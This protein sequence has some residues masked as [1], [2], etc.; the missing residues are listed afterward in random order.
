[1]AR[2]FL[3][4]SLLCQLATSCL[5]SLGSGRAKCVWG[6]KNVSPSGGFTPWQRVMSVLMGLW[7]LWPCLEAWHLLSS[8]HN[9]VLQAFPA[10]SGEPRSSLVPLHWLQKDVRF[11]HG[12]GDKCVYQLPGLEWEAS[13]YGNAS[14]TSHDW[15]FAVV[16]LVN[17]VSLFL[18]AEK[19]MRAS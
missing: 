15:P 4:I 19:K 7:W 2:V 8:C 9:T 16:L 13:P 6:D 3:V 5:G 18:I 12:E 10:A 1:M 14:V 11:H 17:D